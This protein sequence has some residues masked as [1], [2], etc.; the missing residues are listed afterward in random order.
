MRN[1]IQKRKAEPVGP[2]CKALE[3]LWGLLISI[4]AGEF[5]GATWFIVV[6]MVLTF[7]LA[8]LLWWGRQKAKA[9]L[10]G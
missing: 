8:V 5:T 7:L 4:L 6:P 9:I 10:Q 1:I 2:A 3:A